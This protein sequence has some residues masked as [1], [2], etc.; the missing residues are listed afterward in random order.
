MRN[1]GSEFFSYLVAL[2][3]QGMR[4]LSTSR[5]KRALSS[6]SAPVKISRERNAGGLSAINSDR[7][8]LDGGMKTGERSAK[9]PA[10]A[11]HGGTSSPQRN[12]RC[13]PI[14]P[15]HASRSSRRSVAAAGRG[16]PACALRRDSRDRMHRKTRRRPYRNPRLPRRPRRPRPP[17]MWRGAAHGRPILIAFSSSGRRGALRQGSPS[18]K[19]RGRLS[20]D[21]RR[22]S[23]PIPSPAVLRRRNP[24]PR[25]FAAAMP[26]VSSPANTPASRR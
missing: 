14:A 22:T 6:G 19:M 20:P 16:G 3:S 13:S 5:G 21:H 10:L 26:P 4:I 24:G 15:I 18:G 8:A 1:A 11:V 2:S 17:P 7:S 23:C 12:A 25:L 9:C